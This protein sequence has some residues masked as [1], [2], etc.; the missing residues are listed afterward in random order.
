MASKNSGNDEVEED[1]SFLNIAKTNPAVVKDRVLQE[2]LAQ[3][4]GR[5]EPSSTF[6]RTSEERM[7]L[8]KSRE[9]S[10]ERAR[11]R[12]DYRAE[13]RR[14]SQEYAQKREVI[15]KSAK[16]GRTEITSPPERPPT[17]GEARLGDWMRKIEE[18]IKAQASEIKNLKTTVEALRANI[19]E[20]NDSVQIGETKT[21]AS[22]LELRETF[23]GQLQ[24][25]TETI[26]KQIDG[27][28][29][30]VTKIVQQSETKIGASV[31]ELRETFDGQIKEAAESIGKQVDAKVEVARAD[32]VRALVNQA[33]KIEEIRAS[34]DKQIREAVKQVVEKES[35][36]IE[37]TKLKKSAANG[38]FFT[39][40][41]VIAKREKMQGDITSVV[42]NILHKVGSA[43]YYTDVIAV[44]PKTSPRSSAKNAIIYF[45]SVYHKNHAAA[46]IRMMLFREKYV[47]IGIRD[48]FNPADVPRSKDLTAKGFV[49]KKR[50]VISKFRVSNLEDTPVMLVAKRGGAY[51][52]VTDVQ[53]EE[54][55]R[56]TS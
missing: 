8:A 46:Q 5:A 54:M 19:V 42:H 4:Q 2:K 44:H 41:D 48:L 26:G 53:V 27:K 13:L 45:Q 43:P 38:I 37:K 16:R 22:V 14:L 34:F 18:T 17:P 9:N 21:G 32:S 35:V 15:E 36:V 56:R 39:G 30:E 10:A 33:K 51:E 28:I 12:G 24:A 29:V 52:K 20:I 40:L 23:D 11:T 49:L 31:L 3:L 50:D 7:S 25:A 55:L 6:S 47:N 1:F